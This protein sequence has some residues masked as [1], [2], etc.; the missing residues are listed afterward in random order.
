MDFRLHGIYLKTMRAA[1]RSLANRRLNQKQLTPW[2][3][4]QG[5]A[6]EMVTSKHFQNRVSKNLPRGCHS[7]TLEN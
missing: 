7:V 4:G 6:R 3:L 5:T 1:T 2:Q